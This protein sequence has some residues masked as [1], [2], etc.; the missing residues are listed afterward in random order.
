MH[1]ARLTQRG[2][3]AGVRRSWTLS[4]QRT[5]APGS[6]C[7]TSAATT[8][9][10]RFSPAYPGLII[11]DG[12]WPFEL[13]VSFVNGPSICLPPAELAPLPDAE[14]LARGRR[15]VHGNHPVMDG[16]VPRFNAGGDEW[17]EGHEPR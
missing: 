11:D 17:P 3:A 12:L 9:R 14:Y 13:A 15:L 1:G 10:T 6:E 2:P 8:G 7:S 5:Y 16:T 4:S